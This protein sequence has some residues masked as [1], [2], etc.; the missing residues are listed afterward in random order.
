MAQFNKQTHKLPLMIFLQCQQEVRRR[1]FSMAADGRGCWWFLGSSRKTV[2]V[3]K[4]SA[5]RES[6]GVTLAHKRSAKRE[7]VGITLGRKPSAKRE[8]VDVHL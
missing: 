5:K 6:V 1:L 7:N 3:H 4:R 2:D 8:N